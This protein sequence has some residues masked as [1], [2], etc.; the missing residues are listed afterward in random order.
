M[1]V[2]P[3]N[4]EMRNET[5]RMLRFLRSKGENLTRDKSHDKLEHSYDCTNGFTLGLLRWVLEEHKEYKNNEYLFGIEDSTDYDG[6][7]ST[8]LNS[9]RLGYVTDLEYYEEVK[10]RYLAVSGLSS[11][12]HS[13]IE[14]HEQLRQQGVNMEFY[15]A[16]Q[17]FNAAVSI[18]K[19][20]NETKT[21]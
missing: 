19:E 7:Q 12:V 3:A 9:Y 18:H 1:K 2:Q 15:Q 13:V 6:Y 5:A 14:F 11:Y 20:Q 8:Y 4:L 16:Q 17:A 10:A 21:N